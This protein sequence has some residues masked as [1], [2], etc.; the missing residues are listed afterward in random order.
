VYIPRH[1]AV[2]DPET[3]RK[4]ILDNSFATLVTAKSDEPFATHIPLL[5]E[6]DQL[7]GHM[8]RANPHWKAFDGRQALAIFQGPH[9]Y[10]SPRVYVTSPNV[11][12]WNYVTVHVYGKPELIEDPS[13]SADVLYRSMKVYDPSMQLDQAFHEYLQRQLPGIAAFRMP[14][15][16]IEGKFKLN[17][18]KKPEDRDAVIAAFSAS[19]RADELNVAAEMVAHYPESAT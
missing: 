8:A 18:N 17:Q 6:G 16:R 3:L 2:T 1:F 5:L 12:T 7:V 13:E 11:P 10:V 4:V 15:E 9:A 19:T 14:I